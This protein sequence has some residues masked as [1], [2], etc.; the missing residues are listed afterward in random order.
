MKQRFLIYCLTN[1]VTGKRYIGQTV[2]GL[3]ARWA[4]HMK[5]AMNGRGCPALSGAIVKHGHLAF[6]CEVI[7]VVTSQEGA[8][9]A[10]R[11][12]IEHRGTL[13]PHGYNLA[14]GGGAKRFS[15]ETLKKM[16]Q[17]AIR[18]EARLT[19]EERSAR[20]CKASPERRSEVARLRWANMTPEKRAARIAKV[21]ATLKVSAKNTAAIQRRW[22]AMTPEQRSAHS[23]KAH[24]AQTPEQRSERQRKARAT[25]LAKGGAR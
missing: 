18:R 23:R 6:Q 19:P 3:P 13:A 7:D 20:V 11:V 16:S 9:I 22:N 2:Q 10:E 15:V 4:E 21:S 14:G 1:R 8:N 25:Q 24:A 17:A 12:W 5:N